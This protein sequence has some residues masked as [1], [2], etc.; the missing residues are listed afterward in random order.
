MPYS[1][2]ATAT[3]WQ[4]K[5][6]AK[7][8]G[9]YPVKL[10]INFRGRRKHYTT[11]ISLTVHDFEK[12]WLGRAPKGKLKDLRDQIE[13]IRQQALE[14]INKLPKFSF[15]QFERQFF[16]G[17]DATDLDVFA[18][19]EQKIA[20]L[21][22]K[23]Q[24]GSADNYRCAIRS[25]AG[26]LKARNGTVP[27]RLE[28]D[29]INQRFL[30]DYEQY[31]TKEKGQSIS[32]VG[33]YTRHLKAVFNDAIACSA[34]NAYPFGKRSYETP[35]AQKTKK[36]LSVDEL[37]SLTRSEPKSAE[38]RQARDFWLLSFYLYGI[39]LQDLLKVRNRD[40]KASHLVFYRAKTIKTSKKN[41]QPIKIPLTDK[42]RHLIDQYRT[43]D[44][45]LDAYVFPVLDANDSGQEQKRKVRNY[46]RFINQH[47][48][49]LAREIGVS[50]AISYQW[51]RH[52]FA[53]LSITQGGASLE[54]VS[55]ALG[56]H[57]LQT[58]Q[59]YF[60]GFE[61]DTGLEIMKKLTDI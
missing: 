42:A 16:S 13:G 9:T 49:K 32:T 19:F 41:L 31:L 39:N 48:K 27:K 34:T 12:V 8:D 40:I 14:V 45:N 44:Q 57:N 53:T 61:E 21:R 6:R 54:F 24:H 50:P 35:A 56:H 43:A 15:D 30:E 29:R 25:I 18:L 10:H 28:F 4:D 22:E 1:K 59:A 55:E 38:Q 46:V 23:E 33:A 58:T 3:I 47:I 5:R 52:T 17:A 7:Q 37:R 51:A 2:Q 36:A 60:S 20:E 26:Y 11:G